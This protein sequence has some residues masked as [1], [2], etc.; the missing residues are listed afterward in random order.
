M[1][2]PYT[3]EDKNL[4]A[5]DLYLLRALLNAW[6]RHNNIYTPRNP[7]PKHLVFRTHEFSR[8]LR[9]T[10][11]FLEIPAASL[12]A[13]KIFL[14]RS[15]RSGKLDS[16]IGEEYLNEMEAQICEENMAR[17]FP[18]VTDA[19]SAYHLWNNSVQNV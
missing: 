17:H 19:K 16:L 11:E 18:E 9:Q 5:R 12:D 8:A 2:T 14:N 4:E 1:T 6:D 3:P 7:S 15:T 10:T 13:L